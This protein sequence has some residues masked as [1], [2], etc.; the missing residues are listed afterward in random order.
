M[1]ERKRRRKEDGDKK[2]QKRR[3]KEDRKVGCKGGV[4]AWCCVVGVGCRGHAH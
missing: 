1:R 2:K 4:W 3:K